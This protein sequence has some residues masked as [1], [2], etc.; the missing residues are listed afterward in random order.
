MLLCLVSAPMAALSY[1]NSFTKAEELVTVGR[2]ECCIRDGVFYS[3]DSYALFGDDLKDYSF[4]FK[5]RAAEGADQVQIWAGFRVTGRFDR[6]MVG[7]KGGLQDDIYLM[8]VGYMGTDQFLGVRPLGFHPEPGE[9]YTI[10]VE[11]CKSRIR[12]F[13]GDNPV[14]YLDVK[15]PEYNLSP[16]GPVAL[17]GCWIPTEYDD[18]TIEPLAEDALDS[19]PVKEVSLLMSAEDKAALRQEQRTAY[20]PLCVPALAQPRTEIDLDGNW[21]FMPD[22]QV[23]DDFN[24]ADPSVDDAD[25]H[26]MSVPN[27]WN[28]I[29]IWLHGETMPTPNGHQPKGVSDT[30][31]QQ[32]T[33][34]CDDYTFE[35]RKVKYAWYRQWIELPQ[36]L[37][38]KR[39]VLNFDAVSKVADVYVNGVNVASHIGM[40]GDFEADATDMFHPGKN[41]V[42][43]KV[44]KDYIK[45]I[46]NADEVIDV[47]VSLP[48]TNRMLKDIAHGFYGDEPAGIWQPVK[49]VI[50]EQQKIEDVFIR[51]SLK[52][53]EFDF[54]ISNAS[55]KKSIYDLS[56]EIT[57]KETGSVL[58]V[59]SL[60][61]KQILGASAEEVSTYRIEGLKPRL[62]SPQHPNLYD[63][64]FTLSQK[65]KTVD[66]KVIT[67]GFRTFEVKDG[68]FYLNGNKY[69]LR[70]GNH[71]PFALAPNDRNLADTFM[72]LM[73]EGHIDIC[74]THTTPWN[75]LWLDAADRNGIG[76]SHE[77]T[78][79]WLMI[80][81]SPIPD[82]SLLDL[83]RDE[84][85]GMLK[86]Y[87]NHP[88]ILFWTINNEM[89]FYDNDPNIERAKEKIRI[90]SD[91]VGEMR[92]IDPTRPI[93]F[94]SNYR[95]KGMV[96][97]FGADFM[98]TVDDGDIDD[99]HGYYN[100]YD[101]S[102]FRFFNGEF[103][104]FKMPGRPLISQEMSTGYP[105]NETGHP[106][107]SYQQIHQNPISLIGYN[108]YD[109]SDPAY[110]LNTQAFITGELA[111]TLRRTDPEASGIMHFALMTWF[112]QC[113]DYKNIEPYPTYYSLCRALQ[114]VLVSAELWGRHFYAGQKLPV[115]VCVVN[116]LEDGRNLGACVLRWQIEDAQGAVLA[117]GRQDIDG[118]EHYGR[119]W[120]EPQIN[121]PAIAGVRED[122]K[123]R[124]K[125]TE[126]GRVMSQ[127]E[128]DIMIG[129]TSYA[130]V[131]V[132]SG[133]NIFSLTKL[134]V[135][136]AM[137][138]RYSIIDEV[139]N[140]HQSGLCLVD[141]VAEEDAAKL[142]SFIERGGRVIFLGN[143]RLARMVFP[144]YIRDV[145]TPTEGDICFMERSD[146][147]VFD[148][149]G[150]LELRYFNDNTRSIPLVCDH[151][152]KIVR[153]ENVRELAG[154][155]K[156][157]AYIDGGT[158]Q[159][160]L[161]KI[162]S[163]RGF[164]MFE[165]TAGKGSALVSTMCTDKA[166]TDPVAAKLLVNM[167]DVMS[168]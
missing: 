111:E 105:N 67:S 65:G 6:Y 79:T 84:Y 29:R 115:R 77:G 87:R 70:G 54:T 19:V 98:A 120:I 17:G 85:L 127:N 163:M 49:L 142:R 130:D 48:V 63:F 57:D 144:E 109:W 160:R 43:V 24:G 107:R 5:A 59:G 147:P 82:Q 62:W 99:V 45:N 46:K 124:F 69:W 51:P 89:K 164:T 128:Y 13:V 9:W 22:Y 118:V 61:G 136:D 125:L 123:L 92:G 74:R 133:R 83:W 139:S 37:E 25:W 86:K 72:G 12:V 80:A 117:S 91:V 66:T 113:Y 152:L 18:L 15:D 166:V 146:D 33:K 116:D 26:V 76:I 47:A 165:I 31:Y 1:E 126:N 140:L 167:L 30:F 134:P 168:R 121:V 44:V 100:W 4:S 103:Q 122:A 73:H 110:F 159:D 75:E 36:N 8:R 21:L 23:A 94:D 39:M 101:Y 68:L 95:S 151:T 145:I 41:L 88:S 129:T 64:R 81:D 28:P 132:L 53:A 50:T 56:V 71:I 114:P 137:G 90:V 2:G 149:I 11:V 102:L 150:E 10:K 158:Q 27:F 141:S 119:L 161:D 58:Y 138:I 42:A 96:E 14:P 156:I 78:W 52:G 32:E 38:G 93:C 108:C 7:L 112:R 34:R 148:G 35:W 157:H 106:T 104:K 3:K 143:H 162:D 135:L 40:F 131:E 20:A 97:K 153:S 155:M 60:A 55:S 154:Q 16:S